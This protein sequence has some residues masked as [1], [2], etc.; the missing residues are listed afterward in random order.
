MKMKSERVLAIVLGARLPAIVLRP[1]AVQS[2]TVKKLLC[3]SLAFVALTSGESARAADSWPTSNASTPAPASATPTAGSVFDWS[4]FYV[5]AHAGVSTGSST[6]SATQPG[7][8]PN[9]TGSLNFFS[10]FDLYTENGS[11]FGG[12][13]AGYNYMMPSRIVLG[14]EADVSFASTLSATQGLASPVIGT[15]TYSDTVEL[16]GTVRGRVGYDVNHWLFYTTG[17]LA[18]TYDQFNRTTISPG[19]SGSPPAGNAEAVFGGRVG[20]TVGGGVEA[21][22]TAGWSAKAEYLY[23]QFGNTGIFFQASGQSF[24]SNFA[25][26]EFRVGLNYRPGDAPN[27]NGL[28][29]SI[30]PLE[31]D[32]W[33]VRGQTTF[34]DQYD[35][36]FHAPYRGAN[37]LDSNAGRETW[38]ATLYIGRKLWDGAELWINPEIDQGFGLSNTLGIAGFTSGEAYKVGFTN[39]YFRLPRAFIRQT[40]DLGGETQKVD[41]D[42]NQIGGTQTSDKVV[43]TVGRF[44]VPDVFDINKFAHDPRNDFLN[45]S[46]VDAGTFDY[47]ADAWGYTYGASVEWY[48]GNWA[49]RTGLFDLSIVPNSTELDGKF[50]QFQFV[51]ELEHRHEL[52]GQPGKV[53]VTGFLS[54]GRMGSFDDAIALAQQTG[55]T[56]NTADV[57][58]YTSRPGVNL[59]FEQQI[60][61]DVG[62][63]SRVGWADGRVEPFEFTDIDRTA[64]AGLSLGGKLW[65]RPDDAFGLAGVVNGISSEHI[66]YLNAGGLGILVGDGQLPHPGLEQ[67]V[68]AYYRLP[69]GAWQVTGDYQ[70]VQNPGYNRDRGPVSVISLRLRTQF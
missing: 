42:L 45:W 15:A 38:D 57:R 68:E 6:W 49:L 9:L 61:P 19:A 52:W 55:G 16:F 37:S 59:N 47:A 44:G 31:V 54:R 66:A 10:P 58:R 23:A 27:S 7:G 70:F 63:F 34:V 2:I 29:F 1:P 20:W 67:I 53:A 56:P 11:H 60:M 22:I 40:I 28:P 24:T 18:W 64:S 48:Q 14:A 50:D 41:P 33:I 46:L 17:G 69:V 51:Y 3:Q 65:G 21:P 32:N 13:T 62:V 39:P 43:I 30:S 4:G 36:P 12:L 25:T 8:A 26:Q 5:G 35:P